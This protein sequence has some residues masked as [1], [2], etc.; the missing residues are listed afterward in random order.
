[1]ANS[2]ISCVEATQPEAGT[3]ELKEKI[4]IFVRTHVIPAETVLDAGGGDA[5]GT[6]KELRAA[7]RAAGL[8]AL[9]LPVELGG[10]GLTFH[11]YATLAEAEGASDHGPAALGS[12][13]LLDV[14]MLRRHGS[15]RVRE[16]YLKRLVAGEVRS[17]Y[18]M[19]EPGVPGTAPLLTETRA[20]ARPDGAWSVSG[21][22]WFTSGAA[23][24]DLVTVMA[25]T[26]GT[27]HDRD[28]L[29]LFVVP[30]GSPGFRVVRELPVLGAAG[31]YEIELD[32]VLVPADHLLGTGGDALAIAGE[33]LALGRTLRCLRWLGQAQRAFDLMCERAATH[34]GSRGPLADH[35]LVQQHVFDALLALRTTRP[36]VHEAVALIA[37]GKDARTEVGL[38]KVAA[39]RMLQQ[40]ADSAIQVHGAAGLGPDTALPS[41][42]RGGR[43]ARILDGP[44]ELHITSVAG[45]VLR[46]YGQGQG[47]PT[48]E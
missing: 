18:A 33:R 9:P 34:S 4:N 19:T 38:A 48:R 24:A 28:G 47:S 10:G 39:A 43:A 35:Q 6:L 11:E 36:L 46:G 8:W 25:R 27:A 44:D 14:T 7:A 3:V 2:V 29:A 20:E 23:G 21:R 15:N 1:M 12:A 31:Q 32:R 40:V 42:F 26:G 13:A 37:A 45:R 30:T 41:L 16:E 17:C 22:K 5:T